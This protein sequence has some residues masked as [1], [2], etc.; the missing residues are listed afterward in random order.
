MA[1][2][3]AGMLRICAGAACDGGDMHDVMPGMLPLGL[4]VSHQMHA[5]TCARTPE[6]HLDFLTPDS[7]CHATMT[8]LR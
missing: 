2:T 3:D 6:R 7:L 8:D 5:S 1:A 4:S